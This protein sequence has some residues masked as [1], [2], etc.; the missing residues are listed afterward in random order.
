MPN[1]LAQ[2]IASQIWDPNS[3]RARPGEIPLQAK[4]VS[5]LYYG[6]IDRV[7]KQIH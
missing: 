4:N 2:K 1:V 5:A 6:C 3:Q 7:A